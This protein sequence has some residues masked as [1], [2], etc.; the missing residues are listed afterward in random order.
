[1]K[2]LVIAGT[3]SGVG[4]TTVATGIMAALV[5]RGFKVQPFKVGPDYIDPSYHS[6]ACG[7]SS[8]NLDSWLLQPEV[9]IE[10][11]NRAMAGKDLGIIEG[12]MGLYDGAGGEDDIGSTAFSAKMLGLPVVLVIDAS[13]ATRSV[14]ASALGFK[15]FDP[16]LQL[17]GVILNGIAGPKHLELVQPS[18]AQAGIRLLGYL[19]RKQELATPERHLG[20]IPTAE[21]KPARKFYD[22]LADQIERTADLD[23][24]VSVAGHV[25]VPDAGPTVFPEEQLTPRTAIAVARDEAF[26]FYY[27]ESLELLEAWGAELIP[28]SPLADTQLPATVGGVYIGGGFP[29]FFAKELSQNRGML[30]SLRQAAQRDLPMYAEC[31]GLMYLCQTLEDLDGKTEPMAGI[32]PAHCSMVNTGL[33]LGY[34]TVRALEDS[35]LMKADQSVRGHEFHLS[36]LKDAT[37]GAPAYEVLGHEGR[38]EGFRIGNVLAS[39]VHLHF[40]SDK[41]LAPRF[42]QSCTEWMANNRQGGPVCLRKL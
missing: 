24:L 28:F 11:F 23:C 35:P 39:Y 25:R 42:V 6:G 7:V 32:V 13:A 36:V 31:G 37:A 30:H 16:D 2:A 26:N 3:H 10:V 5:R 27:P 20:L 19:P 41:R 40:G 34:R 17:A 15:H 18:L 12:V 9:L 14:G 1:M 38:R 4:K 21:G 29:E 33:T 22:Q 8:R